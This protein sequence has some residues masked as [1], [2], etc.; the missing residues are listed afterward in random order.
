MCEQ[1]LAEKLRGAG[2]HPRILALLLSWLEPR[3]FAVVLD[4]CKSLARR[5]VN[6]VY[7]GTVLGA[8][9]W[10]MHYADSSPRREL[11]GGCVC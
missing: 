7:Q 6:S 9:L 10:N 4:G 11:Q 8:P 2:L 1:R 5:L 3:Q